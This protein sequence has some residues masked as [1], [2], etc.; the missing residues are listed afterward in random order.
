MAESAPDDK[1][2]VI[3]QLVGQLRETTV[4][5][6]KAELQLLAVGVLVDTTD[7]VVFLEVAELLDT[8]GR[9]DVDRG[10]DALRELVVRKPYLAPVPAHPTR[11][12]GHRY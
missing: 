10:R 7:A 2:A 4:A 8:T 11:P 1:D 5:L 3:A 12:E 6:A 9:L